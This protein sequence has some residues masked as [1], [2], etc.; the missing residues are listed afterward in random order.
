MIVMITHL[1]KT[2]TED[3]HVPATLDT[4]AMDIRAQVG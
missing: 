1:A 4:K 3:S 2:P